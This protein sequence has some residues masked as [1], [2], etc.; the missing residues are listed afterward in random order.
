[1]SKSIC[2]SD[3]FTIDIDF[4]L[5]SVK[6]KDFG[7]MST[8]SVGRKLENYVSGLFNSFDKKSRPTVGSG[9]KLEIS[10]LICQHFYVECKKRNTKDITLQQKVW[11][12]L[13]T[14]IPADS[15][16]APLYILENATENKYVVMDIKDFVRMAKE[17]YGDK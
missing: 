9:S 11:D 16:K 12:K 8:R 15:L 1:M 17:L 7:K 10:D 2:F 6:Q 3:K 13:C 4:K 14:E 5:T